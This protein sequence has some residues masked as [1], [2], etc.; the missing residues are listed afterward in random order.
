LANT[1]SKLQKLKPLIWLFSA[2]ET[3]DSIRGGVEALK[4]SSSNIRGFLVFGQAMI[5]SLGHAFYTGL[6]GA[7]VSPIVVFIMLWITVLTVG[8]VSHIYTWIWKLQRKFSGKDIPL[9]P[10]V[11]GI[12]VAFFNWG[13]RAIKIP[14]AE[15]SPLLAGMFLLSVAAPIALK[16]VTTFRIDGVPPDFSVGDLLFYIPGLLLLGIFVFYFQRAEHAISAM[17]KKAKERAGIDD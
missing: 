12:F 5:W 13:N 9:N 16:T 6:L 3:I 17:I 7:L 11:I 10:R 15:I 14:G 4:T 2:I 8:A 1:K